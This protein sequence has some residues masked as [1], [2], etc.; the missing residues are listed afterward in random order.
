MKAD[1]I[2]AR[3]I[4]EIGR[5]YLWWDPVSDKPHSESRTLVKEAGGAVLPME[6][7]FHLEIPCYFPC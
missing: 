6:S 3:S 7:A 4:A 1:D 2:T 5:K